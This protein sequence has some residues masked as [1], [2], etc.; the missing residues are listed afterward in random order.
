[1][2]RV[3]CG[4]FS[5]WADSYRV[6]SES[7][8]E[9]S[10]VLLSLFGPHNAVRATWAELVS[11]KRRWNGVQVGGEY[12]RLAQ[13]TRYV[14]VRRAL[15]QRVLHLVMLHPE[16]TVQASPFS[17]S[18]FL[19]G[20]DPEVA[21]WPRLC[22]MCAV[23]LRPTWREAVWEIGQRDGHIVLLDGFGL[24][25]WRIRA[26]TEPWAATIGEAVRKGQLQ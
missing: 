13:S 17:K 26:E 5:C 2:E 18:F 21:F 22:R 11:S 3:T 24:P 20:T 6:V 19:P 23:P 25:V 12:V 10:L 9:T 14:S 4:K 1:V 8:W 7:R 15:D 16:A